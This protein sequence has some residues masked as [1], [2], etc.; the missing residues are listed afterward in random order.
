LLA[1]VGG[2]QRIAKIPKHNQL[3]PTGYYPRPVQI[4][5]AKT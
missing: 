2:C 5:L 3:T 4:Q 1:I